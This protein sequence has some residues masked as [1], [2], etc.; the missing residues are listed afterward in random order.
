MAARIIRF[1]ASSFSEASKTV[2]R[3]GLVVYPTDTV[4]GL[5][6]EPS[7][8]VAVQRLFAVKKREPKP[9]PLMCDSYKTASTLVDL[10]PLAQQVARHLWP[11]AL[12]IV[13]PA[14][15][16]L[17]FPIHQ[18]EGTLGVRV[19][20][21]ALCRKL[22]RACGGVLTGTSANFSGNPSCRSAEEAERELGNLVDLILDGG[23]LV[24]AESTVVRIIGEGIEVL[25]QG[26]VRVTE[27][28]T[29]R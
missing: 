9:I 13:A 18:G 12:T 2:R 15:A 11:G 10:S 14:R 26:A 28:V 1:D 4:Y 19:P 7:N 23:R 5:G 16:E 21:S 17:P 25:R 6:C 27:K 8:A 29:T 22:V 3:G 24:A 20:G